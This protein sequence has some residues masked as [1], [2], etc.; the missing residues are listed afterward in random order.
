MKM[1]Y[2]WIT[3]RCYF[4]SLRIIYLCSSMDITVLCSVTW[5]L[6]GSKAGGD[7]AIARSVHEG[8][9]LRFPC[10]DLTLG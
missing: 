6:N 7:L 1:F 5:S 4:A 3:I 9:V 8:L 10:N 2:I